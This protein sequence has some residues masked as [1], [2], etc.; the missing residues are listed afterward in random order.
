MPGS[1]ETWLFT[2]RVIALVGFLTL[3]ILLGKNAFN[4]RL[5]HSLEA[6]DNCQ[7]SKMVQ[8]PAGEFL[9]GSDTS[10]KD[11]APAHQVYLDSY[12]I[13]QF[14]VTNGEY[15]I[16]IRET[17][18]E[19]PRYWEGGV[20]PAG[21]SSYPVVGVRWKDAQAFC[22]WT[23]KRL[24]TEAEWEKACRGPDGQVY[25]WGDFP[26][27][28]RANVGF[29]L[30]GP[31]PEMW[32]EAWDML[33]SPVGTGQ[34]GLQPAGNYPGGA[35][36]YGVHD[37]VG[38]ASE[39]VADYY[40]WDG[41]REINTRNPFVLEPTWNHVLRGSAWLMPYGGLLDGHD[42]SRCAARSSSHGDTRDA[43]IGFRCAFNAED[44]TPDENW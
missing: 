26:D 24:P 33:I 3:S 2:S 40:N 30:D 23:G 15:L 14:E 17:N 32:E 39:W 36:L 12:W 11:E 43:R 18:R 8:I 41:Y 4:R 44:Q 29:P 20:Y 27:P 5:V 25:P 6:Q 1:K 22:E 13:D 35:S 7:F 37:L 42:T 38:N 19:P 21:Q 34:P 9:M 31:S 28:Q 16:F 10:R